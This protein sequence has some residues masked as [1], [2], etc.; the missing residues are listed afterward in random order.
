M[1]TISDS[2]IARRGLAALEKKLDKG[3][4]HVIKDDQLAYVVL[5]EA[6]YSRLK[7]QPTP[8]AGNRPG[9]WDILLGTS[10]PCLQGRSRES[11]DADI[12]AE[13]DAWDDR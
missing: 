4:V 7:T 13:R 9:V 5:T 10:G 8:G 12:S 3:P 6:E 2:E 11:M 1:Q